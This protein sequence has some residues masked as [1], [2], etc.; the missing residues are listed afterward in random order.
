M[1]QVLSNKKKG[2]LRRRKL[3]WDKSKSGV[4]HSRGKGKKTTDRKMSHHN[5]DDK[6]PYWVVRACN[7]VRKRGRVGKSPPRGVKARKSI[8]TTTLRCM[9]PA[10]KAELGDSWISQRQRQSSHVP[11]RNADILKFK[12]KFRGKGGETHPVNIQAGPQR[13]CLIFTK[14]GKDRQLRENTATGPIDSNDASPPEK[15]PC[16]CRVW[17]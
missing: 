17:D 15:S 14:R 5:G 7:L 4:S 16:S 8:E 11:Y 10:V 13:A 2:G 1:P 3:S 6:R 12:L 9:E